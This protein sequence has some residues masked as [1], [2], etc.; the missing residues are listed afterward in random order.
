MSSDLLRQ[1]EHGAAQI[2]AWLIDPFVQF[3]FRDSLLWWPFLLSAFAVALAG[4]WATHGRDAAAFVEFR[5]RF[6]GRALWAHR[7]AQADYAYYI[8]NTLIY[9]LIVAPL[10]ISSAAFARL[11]ESGLARLAGPMGA[12]L[13]GIGWT[14]AL[15]TVLFYLAYDWGRF[16]AHSLLHEA[17]LLWQFHKVHHS[18]EVLTPITSFRTH[19]VELFVMAVIPNAATG[20]VSGIVWYLS[21]GEVGFYTFLG[22]HV[23]MAATGAI[24]NLRHWQVWI[25]FGPVLN[26]W[27]I[28]PAHHQIHH[29]RE[30]RHFGMNRGFELAIWDRLAG[31]L[32]VPGAEEKFAMGLGDGSDGAWHRVARLYAWPFRYALE[33]LGVG[34]KPALPER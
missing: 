5:R 2:L 32:Y 22:L 26:R 20:L 24:G 8:V 30:L 19:P 23:V 14:R 6:L 27:L 28:S 31:T 15:Y 33:L 12:P 25:S 34:S 16:A 17:P 11:I 4:F 18:A 3:L 21:A 9:P 1:V 7:S 10:V 13:L 29:S